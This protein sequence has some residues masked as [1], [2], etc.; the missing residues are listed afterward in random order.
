MRWNFRV[1][2]I[3]VSQSMVQAQTISPWKKDH[4]IGIP[5]KLQKRNTNQQQQSKHENK[6]KQTNKQTNKQAN[7]QTSKQTNKQASKQT[8]KQAN[9]QT[10]KQTNKETKK[11][12]NKQASKQASKQAVQ[13]TC[14]QNRSKMKAISQLAHYTNSLANLQKAR[15]GKTLNSF[16][17]FGFYL[18]TK[19]WAL[20]WVV[21]A[22]LPPGWHVVS[23]N[24]ARMDPS[25]G[26]S[27]EGW[28][29]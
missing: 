18:A 21:W 14:K 7:K 9:K 28:A 25:G 6:Q 8:N 10:S 2:G 17:H 11:Q 15:R 24:Q 5:G 27:I 26:S 12:R 1:Y 22:F 4:K 13:Q 23:P 20:C 3:E 16:F 19:A 29:S